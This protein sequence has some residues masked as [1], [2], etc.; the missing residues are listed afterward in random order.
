[1]IRPSGETGRRTGLK[2]PGPEQG[3]TG[4]IP[5]L[6]TTKQRIFVKDNISYEN[7][8]ERMKQK[9]IETYGPT[10]LHKYLGVN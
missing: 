1:M 6:G 3:R 4:S 9:D 7:F 8:L 10:E 2:I 5:V